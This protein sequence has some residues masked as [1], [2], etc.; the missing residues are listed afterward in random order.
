MTMIVVA[1]TFGSAFIREVEGAGLQEF[2]NLFA[3]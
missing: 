1:L 2:K 3:L